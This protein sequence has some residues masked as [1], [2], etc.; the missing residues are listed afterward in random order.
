MG[1]MTMASFLVLSGMLVTGQESTAL[2]SRAATSHASLPDK[3]KNAGGETDNIVKPPKVEVFMCLKDGKTKTLYVPLTQNGNVQY[4]TLG[5]KEIPANIK[6]IDVIH[7]WAVAKSGEKGFFVFPNGMYGTF[8][9]TKDGQYRNYNTTMQMIGASTPRGAMTMILTGLNYEAN[10]FVQLKKGNYKVFPQYKLEN[11]PLYE[12]LAIE[13][14]LLPPDATYADMAKVYR[15]YQLDRGE[16]RPLKERI[17]DNPQ[18][19]YAVNSMEVRVRLAWKPVPS[20]VGEQTAETEPPMKVA[21]SF[22]RFLQIVNE[23][24]RQKIDKAEF[25]LV[26]WNIGGHDGRYPQIF[27]V[28]ERLGGE[29]NLRDVI[30][31][32]QA[33]GYQIV[34]H[35][36]NSDAYSVSRIAGL[37]DENYLRVDTTGKFVTNT[38]WG[39]GNMYQTCPKCVF[40]R[41]VQNDLAKIRK[42]GFRGL[43][44]IDVYSTVDPRSCYS[45]EHPLSKRDFANWTKKIF[46]Q[47][48]KEFG[49]LGS[50][51][52]FDY[53]ISNLDYALY[54]SFFN[55]INGKYNPLIE[56]HVPIWQL[57]YNGIVLNN[58]FT[59]T[60]N[61][62]IKG[63]AATLKMFEYGGRPMFY[64][65]SKFKS[66]GSNWMGDLDMACATNE[67]LVASVKKIKQGYDDFESV[68]KLQLEFMESHDQL[69]D[70]VFRTGF[71]DGTVIITNYGNNPFVYKD[72]TVAPVGY[73]I[74]Q[75][76]DARSIR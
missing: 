33:A 41:F 38:T 67:E 61:Y 35:T 31:K 57:V 52:G 43:H 5:R 70:E 9:N 62:T 73:L 71:S 53:C 47:A 27:P 13:F 56:R 59:A 11:L 40:E 15:K 32:T 36:N 39:G 20:P 22:D 55:P 19:E 26:G 6:T 2:R 3:K 1:I 8:K 17:K 48:Q 45:K 65:Y 69:A 14:H 51:G 21:I 68:R 23:F 58:P 10:H 64:F 74:T 75:E 76:K 4:F 30:A 28:D 49:G 50:E 66:S 25:C 18:L 34:C 46:A 72:K 54:I 16:V 37:W 42:L 63:P 44:Y 29:K 24:K 60:T 12:D 7:P